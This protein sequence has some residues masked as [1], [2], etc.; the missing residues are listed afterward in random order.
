MATPHMTMLVRTQKNSL[1]WGPPYLILIPVYDIRRWW[2]KKA[3]VCV[4]SCQCCDDKSINEDS[5]RFKDPEI[6]L[7]LVWCMF[8]HMLKVHLKNALPN[9]PKFRYFLIRSTNIFDIEKSF[10]FYSYLFL[11][12]SAQSP[13]PNT[14]NLL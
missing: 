13:K 12:I 10:N 11:K 4:K 8:S 1:P 14:R 7:Y 9:N 3:S 5:F 2:D 6:T